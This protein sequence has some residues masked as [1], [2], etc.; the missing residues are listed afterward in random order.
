MAPKSTRWTLYS[1]RF[2]LEEFDRMFRAIPETPEL[3]ALRSR[4]ERNLEALRAVRRRYRLD[5]VEERADASGK[6]E[7]AAMSAALETQPA[8]VEGALALLEVTALWVLDNEE[9]YFEGE[10]STA[11]A[12]A[13]RAALKVLEFH[14]YGGTIRKASE[15]FC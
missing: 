11:P 12:R 15:E 14:R 3:T 6:A 4:L 10:L 8:T 7:F 2:S 9:F 1:A 13:T 5:E